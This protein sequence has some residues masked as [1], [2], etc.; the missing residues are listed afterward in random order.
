MSACSDDILLSWL[1]FMRS[2]LICSR[3]VS[4]PGVATYSFGVCSMT[5]SCFRSSSASAAFSSSSGSLG[6]ASSSYW[7]DCCS[8]SSFLPPKRL[9]IKT[10]MIRIMRM[11]IIKIAMSS[12]DPH[13]SIIPYYF[14][15]ALTSSPSVSSTSVS[16]TTSP[17][18]VDELKDF[19][20]DAGLATA[21]ALSPSTRR[22][23]KLFS[24][25]SVGV[26]VGS[27]PSGNGC[28]ILCPSPPEKKLFT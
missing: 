10:M 23:V 13:K 1:S 26:V 21:V 12:Q 22:L 4:S 2:T 5:I 28:N 20:A 7:S 19:M 9:I 11:I 24:R 14:E 16:G 3:A 17:S 25:V 15:S 18:R 8:S 6:C 27:S